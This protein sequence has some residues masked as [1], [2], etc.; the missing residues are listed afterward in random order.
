MSRFK[1]LCLLAVLVPCALALPMGRRRRRSSRGGD[2]RV[3]GRVEDLSEG[4]EAET[5]DGG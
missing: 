1:M 4:V 5:E 2:W 3:G